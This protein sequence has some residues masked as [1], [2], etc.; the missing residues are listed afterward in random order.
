MAFAHVQPTA[1]NTS[2]TGVASITAT[3]GSAVS[4]GSIVIGIVCFDKGVSE[5]LTGVSD[6]AG[7]TYTIEEVDDTVNHQGVASFFR[8]NITNAPTSVTASFT[9]SPFSVSIIIDEYSGGLAVADPR[10][11]H[12]GNFQTAPGT[13]T[14]ALVSTSITT[15]VNGDL[16]WGGSAQT[17]ALAGTINSGTGETQRGHIAAVTNVC[18]T[19]TEDKVQGTAGAVQSTFTQTAASATVTF[20][21]AVQ[22]AATQNPFVQSNWTTPGRPGDI[23]RPSTF[24][25]I[26]NQQTNQTQTQGPITGSQCL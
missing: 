21:I 3:F 7:N 26:V 14:D 23:I 24:N 16:I 19:T 8:S 5:T 10:D 2:A 17:G 20:V 18:A 11:G 22:P 6:N 25:N 15:T 9:N 1:T 12:N 13:G 4:S